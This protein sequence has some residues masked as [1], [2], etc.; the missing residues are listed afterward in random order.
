MTTPTP[1]QKPAE[2][3]SFSHMST[4]DLAKMLIE[5]SHMFQD[6]KFC[7]ALADEIKKRKPETQ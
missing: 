4:N 3:Y 7:K 2:S 6:A 1:D 5:C